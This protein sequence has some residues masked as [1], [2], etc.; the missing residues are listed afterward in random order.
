MSPFA[1][2]FSFHNQTCMVFIGLL[3]TGLLIQSPAAELSG[4]A[5]GQETRRSLVHSTPYL[6]YSVFSSEPPL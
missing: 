1:V 3:A 6:E 5:P 2:S 4:T